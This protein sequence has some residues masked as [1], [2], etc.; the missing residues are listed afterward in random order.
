MRIDILTIFPPMIEAVLGQSILK[1]ALEKGLVQINVCDIRRFST[2]KHSCVDDY[3]F[4]GGAGMVMKPEPLVAA[5]EDAAG[6][7]PDRTGFVIYMSPQ[8]KTL[9]HQIVR[10]LT[11]REHLVIVCGRYEGVDERVLEGWVDEEL[12]I[13]DYVVSGGELP[14]M[15]LTDAIVRLIPGVLGNE[16]SA[17]LDSFFHGLLDYPHYTRPREFRG[18][19]VPEVLLS[20]D[21]AR[22][23]AWRRR[24]ALERTLRRR[25]DLLK[26]LD[27]SRE[28]ND[29][30]AELRRH[31]DKPDPAS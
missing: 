20:G 17:K 11:R 19:G 2:D 12:S 9:T 14:A 23:Q 5:I 13:G 29:I 7:G 22:I 25:P 31:Q 15:V 26:K 4:G 3:P 18:R 21:H 16:E 27:L 28:D 30:I 6:V 1:R 24:K 8:G 10:E